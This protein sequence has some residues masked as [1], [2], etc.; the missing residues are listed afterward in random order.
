MSENKRDPR[1]G[2]VVVGHDSPD[3][4]AGIEE[5]DGG[6]HSFDDPAPNWDLFTVTDFVGAGNTG[7]VYRASDRKSNRVVA[8]KF[9]HSNDPAEVRRFQREARSQA[10][11]D[12]DHVCR[13]YDVGEVDG[14]PFI[15]MQFI[16]GRPLQDLAADLSLESKVRLMEQVA[17]AAQVAHSIGII[18]RDIKPA[19]IM[20]E[21][22]ENGGYHA[23]VLDFGIARAVD[24][25]SLTRQG[26]VVG[27]PAYMAPEQIRGDADLVDRRADVYGIGATLYDVIAGEVPFSGSTRL[28]TLMHVLT[29]EPRP[30]RH[31]DLRIP[32][33]LETI[34]TT[35]M[36]KDPQRRYASARA[37]ADD[38][39]RYLAGERIVARR[40]GLVSRVSNFVRRLVG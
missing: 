38:L 1:I 25:P 20:V 6:N 18:H 22:G 23:Y 9:L 13:I 27:T 21:M 32:V 39:R 14:R 40:S 17:W 19:N 2:P 31:L 37:L 29:E 36:E 24:G 8:L 30:L 5:G 33:D 26:M 7:R 10:Q 28:E 12:H 16:D 11:I 3:D 34:V 15:A 4:P 35:C